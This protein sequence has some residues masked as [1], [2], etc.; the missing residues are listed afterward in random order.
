MLLYAFQQWQGEGEGEG[1]TE[2]ETTTE[3]DD[4]GENTEPVP[5]VNNNDN[6]DTDSGNTTVAPQNPPDYG[7]TEAPPDPI[8]AAPLPVEWPLLQLTAVVGSGA[9]GS[10]MINNEI[11]GVGQTIEGAKIVAIGRQ[12]A[13]LEYKGEK[14]FVSVEFVSQ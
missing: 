14:R 9:N 12:G 2:K 10:V 5:V 4:A 6:N 3:P 8:N 13:W 1:T 7:T 11:L